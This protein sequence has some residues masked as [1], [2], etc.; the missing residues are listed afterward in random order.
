MINSL[1]VNFPIKRPYI[2]SKFTT[3]HKIKNKKNDLFTRE[4][5]EDN[6]LKTYETICNV[7]T[8]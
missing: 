3:A 2:Q 1:G 8:K 4:N 7:L 5:L 6:Y